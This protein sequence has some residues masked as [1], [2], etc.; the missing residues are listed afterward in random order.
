MNYYSADAHTLLD[1]MVTMRESSNME[2][3]NELA[4]L[5]AEDCLLES[6]WLS[7]HEEGK[8]AV[9]AWLDNAL[10]D[11]WN[12]NIVWHYGVAEILSAPDTAALQGPFGLHILRETDGGY[13]NIVI[14]AAV[15]TQGKVDRIRIDD[16]GLYALQV[17]S[18]C[19][20]MKRK[21]EDWNDPSNAFLMPDTYWDYLRVGMT[22]AECHISKISPVFPNSLLEGLSWW[23]RFCKA[24][25]FDAAFEELTGT[26]YPSGRCERPESARLLG[27]M[28]KRL[29]ENREHALAMADHLTAWTESLPDR[30]EMLRLRDYPRNLDW[31]GGVIND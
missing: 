22:C 10:E 14:T 30:S 1:F 24:I 31:I 17:F 29:W 2:H 19:F 18:R 4:P 11:R 12:K 8:T 9:K 15:D 6:E 23:R 26:D 16:A 13:N 25:N 28:G 3:F 20:R 7:V 27:W 21:S 5:L